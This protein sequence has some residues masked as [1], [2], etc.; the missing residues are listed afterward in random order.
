MTARGGSRVPPAATVLEQRARQVGGV[1]EAR[2]PFLL[3]GQ[4]GGEDGGDTTLYLASYD[5]GTLT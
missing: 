3:V 5:T 1:L 2:P 4:K